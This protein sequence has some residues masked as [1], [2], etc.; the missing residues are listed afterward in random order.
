MRSLI[1]C[2]NLYMIQ[3]ADAGQILKANSTPRPVLLRLEAASGPHPSWGN[4]HRDQ[5]SRGCPLGQGTTS[6]QAHSSSIFD[7]C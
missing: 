7:C 4:V 6:A 2:E 3:K 1:E 5:G